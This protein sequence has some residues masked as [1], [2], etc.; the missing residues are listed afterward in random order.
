[1]WRYKSTSTWRN[2][3]MSKNHLG[4]HH[5]YIKVGGYP[6]QRTLPMN[7]FQYLLNSTYHCTVKYS[8][9]DVT[10][11]KKKKGGSGG[12]VLLHM[13]LWIQL[14]IPPD[15]IVKI[16]LQVTDD[17]LKQF[18]TMTPKEDVTVDILLALGHIPDILQCRN[19]YQLKSKKMSIFVPPNTQTYIQGAWV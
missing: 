5:M 16:A 3:N 9:L 19:K 7:S 1:M 18:S 15:L 8:Q 12:V 13:Y 17:S 6:Y 4:Q 14:K 11:T 10:T 2:S